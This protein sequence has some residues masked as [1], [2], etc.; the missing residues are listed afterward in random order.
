MHDDKHYH[1]LHGTIENIT[2]T[3][4]I[5]LEELI[6]ILT[7]FGRANFI[8]S[9]MEGDSR[10]S[11]PEN[12]PGRFSL[13]RMMSPLFFIQTFV[14]FRCVFGVSWK[15]RTTH[16][17]TTLKLGEIDSMIVR[18][19]TYEKGVANAAAAMVSTLRR[20]LHLQR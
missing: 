9:E 18:A 6:Q 3:S 17:W 20:P 15:T 19:R 10:E 5:I 14:R 1:D 8:V 13:G 16:A 11:G 2:H 4:L 12:D 7:E